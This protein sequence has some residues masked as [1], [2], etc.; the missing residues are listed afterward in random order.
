MLK[1]REKMQK[2]V[3]KIGTICIIILF[4]TSVNGFTQNEPPVSAFFS[5]D[6]NLVLWKGPI[7]HP[8]FP[9]GK[10][11]WIGYYLYRKREGENKFIKITPKPISCV[12]DVHELVRII[13]KGLDFWMKIL[14]V[15]TPDEFWLKVIS[16]DEKLHKLSVLDLNLRIALGLAYLDKNIEKGKSYQYYLVKVDKKGNESTPSQIARVVFPEL[17]GPK[18][19]RVELDVEKVKITWSPNPEDKMIFGYNV[20]RSIDPEGYFS[21]LNPFRIFPTWEEKDE[22]LRGY[23]YDNN[24]E[25][26]QTYYYYVS[27]VDLAGNESPRGEI[28]KVFIKDSTPP[29]IPKNIKIEPH[30]TG[31]KI[32]WERVSDKDLAGY[33]IYRSEEWDGEYKKINP[34]LIPP[35]QTPVFIDQTVKPNKEYYYRVT[36]VDMYNN[37]SEQSIKIHGFFENMRA[38]LPPQ[39]VVAKPVEEGIMISWKE[40]KEPDLKGYYVFRSESDEEKPVQI[41]SFLPKGTTQYID[42][43]AYLNSKGKYWYMVKAINITGVMSPFSVPYI[44]SPI[45]KEPPM[46]PNGFY[47]YAEFNKIRLFWN[48]ANDNTVVGYRVYRKAGQERKFEC[49]TEALIPAY[50]TLTFTDRNVKSTIVYYYYVVSVDKAGNESEPTQILNF[51]LPNQLPQPPSN[52]RLSIAENGILLEWS[53]IY[54]GDIIGYHIYRRIP[55]GKFIKISEKL[56]PRDVTNYLDNKVERGMRYYYYIVSVSSA[57]IES[58]R[59]KIIYLKYK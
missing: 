12:K 52:L 17:K 46:K 30:E 5:P 59:S 40:N 3:Y 49:L 47:G 4:F 10:E 26:G 57:G 41:S 22:N 21:K 13:G 50:S 7:L 15:K 44:A 14:Q 56:V 58:E 27:S 6:G 36:S 53:P 38:P 34:V 23:F 29:S 32:F 18:D 11:E 37:E 2:I 35:E 20:Y 24:I 28:V 33:N 45:D 55:K 54:G 42:R 39:D 43:D 48:N 9:F 51:S 25:I 16:N 8:S 31:V 1:R 19:V